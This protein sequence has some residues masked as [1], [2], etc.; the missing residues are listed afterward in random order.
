MTLGKSLHYFI[1]KMG[2]IIM[3]PTHTSGK[4][5][6][7]KPTVFSF[8]LSPSLHHSI[9]SWFPPVLGDSFYRTAFGGYSPTQILLEKQVYWSGC[10]PGHSNMR[11]SESQQ[12]TASAHSSGPFSPSAPGDRVPIPILPQLTWLQAFRREGVQE[13][14]RGKQSFVL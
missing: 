1:S 10:S 14:G 5:G 4:S 12:E 3:P 8:S 2:A 11:D 7:F 6:K 9:H 13:K